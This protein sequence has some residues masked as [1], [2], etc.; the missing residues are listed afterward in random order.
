MRRSLSPTDWLVRA[1]ERIPCVFPKHSDKQT[2]P[3]HT[4][5]YTSAYLQVYSRVYRNVD[6]LIIYRCLKDRDRTSATSERWS[7]ERRRVPNDKHNISATSYGVPNLG[8]CIRKSQRIASCRRVHLACFIFLFGLCFAF[9]CT[10]LCIEHSRVASK[11]T[12]FIRALYLNGFPF[13][14]CVGGGVF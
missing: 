11:L 5:T 8:L 13:P 2:T 3:R 12:G 7:D 14:C 10:Y 4:H 6:C 9:T 1:S